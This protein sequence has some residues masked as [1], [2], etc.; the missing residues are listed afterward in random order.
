MIREFK[1]M[2]GGVGWSEEGELWCT[3][4]KVNGHTKGACP[5]KLICDICQVM[6]HSTK[7]CTY[8]LRTRGP[9]VLFTQ[10]HPSTF[11]A[12]TNK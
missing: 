8:N 4:C 12:A 7:D 1:V 2:K 6:G 11:E 9:Q 5:K 10:Q 3:E